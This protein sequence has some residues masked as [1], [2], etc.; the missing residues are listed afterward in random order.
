[1]FR[2]KDD[3]RI[4]LLYK[5]GIRKYILYMKAIWIRIVLKRNVSKATGCL[6]L[7]GFIIV[8][9]WGSF[10]LSINK[11]KQS[12]DIKRKEMMILFKRG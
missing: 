12:T 7:F 11:D 3:V 2:K 4:F 8:K 1:M 9:V 6:S 5:Q 10:L